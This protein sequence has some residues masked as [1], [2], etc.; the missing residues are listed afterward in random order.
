ME[1]APL[2]LGLCRGGLWPPWT[3][4][5]LTGI[6]RGRTPALHDVLTGISRAF[7]IYETG[8]ILQNLIDCV[9]KLC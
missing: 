5:P 9:G 6:G 3:I 2:L 1:G 4:Y 7:R 8:R